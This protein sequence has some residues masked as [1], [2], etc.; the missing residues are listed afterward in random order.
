V[1]EA[2][3]DDRAG[4]L[5][6]A[7]W[8]AAAELPFDRA[9]SL[10]SLEA[11]FTAGSP[12]GTLDGPLRGRLLA[13]T[14]GWGLDGP[15]EALTRLWMPWMGKAFD[16]SAAEG[17]NLFA[18]GA[19]LPIRLLWPRYRGVHEGGGATRAFRFT[20]WTGPSAL[21][22]GVDVTKI[23]YDVPESPDLLIR[24]ILDEIVRVD[25]RLYLGQALLRRRGA[26]HRV[27]WF[28]LEE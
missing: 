13:T 4:A 21:A 28:S 7:Y 10:R 6:L 27:A 26:Y 5:P 11:C 18:R 3:V 9:G 15:F 19:R 24:P 14:F 16:A 12:A 23:D 22:P 2:E 8:R 17:E 25:D 20:T 1:Q